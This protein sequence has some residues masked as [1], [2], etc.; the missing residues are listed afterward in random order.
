SNG[1]LLA[2]ATV[3]LTH[4]HPAGVQTLARQFLAEDRRLQ[5]NL[6]LLAVGE[7][8]ILTGST[9]LFSSWRAGGI[10]PVAGAD[11]REWRL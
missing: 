3:V 7:G 6:E 1:P 9:R 2:G 4:C 5:E 8:I 10:S 11:S